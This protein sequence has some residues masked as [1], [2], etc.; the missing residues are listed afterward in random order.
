[1]GGF[2]VVAENAVGEM[3]VG[4][5]FA[6]F[7]FCDVSGDFGGGHLVLEKTYSLFI[8]ANRLDEF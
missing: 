2:D 7:L 8:V 6:T 5:G 3:E 1:M 4:G